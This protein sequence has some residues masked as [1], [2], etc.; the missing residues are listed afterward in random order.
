MHIK[1]PVVHVKS[2]VDYGSMKITSMH[3]Y[4]QR[5]NVAV[6]VVEELKTITYST[7]PS[8]IQICAQVKDPISTCHKR[9]GL[10][11]GGMKI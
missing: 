8:M 11:A 10:T 7:P 3:L 9:V 1:N 5:W 4:P 6:Q 2:L